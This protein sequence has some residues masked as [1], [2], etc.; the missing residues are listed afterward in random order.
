[1][2]ESFIRIQSDY[3]L[4][5]FDCSIIKSKQ[6][7]TE[8]KMAAHLSGLHISKNYTS[9]NASDDTNQIEI[10]A[11]PDESCSVQDIEQKLKQANR[12]TVSDV[13]RSI[14][15]DP[16]LPAAIMERFERP[17]KALVLWQPPQ[18]ITEMIMTKISE[19][20]NQNDDEQISDDGSGTQNT[21]TND[22]TQM[23]L[24]V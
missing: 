12:I 5:L 8:E 7:I 1:M 15:D 2:K 23:D 6:L 4:F 13:V 16:L 17:S 11:D 24:D 18:R 21:N 9:H 14:Q 10:V 3:F 22:A 19:N 20:T